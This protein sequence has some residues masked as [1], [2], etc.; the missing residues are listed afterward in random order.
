MAAHEADPGKH[1]SPEEGAAKML[2]SLNIYPY[3]VPPLA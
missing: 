2:L 3:R 1:L